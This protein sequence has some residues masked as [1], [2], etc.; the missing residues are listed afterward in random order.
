MSLA[1]LW[2]LQKALASWVIWALWVRL[3]QPQEPLRVQLDQAQA[4]HRERP[5]SCLSW[6]CALVAQCSA[7]QKQ[8]LDLKPRALRNAEDEVNHSSHNESRLSE[9]LLD[10]SISTSKR[11]FSRP[12]IQ[13]KQ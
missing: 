11:E 2:L 1:E 4:H 7:R 8:T 9:V 6:G 5:S 10:M 3:A 13:K 12:L